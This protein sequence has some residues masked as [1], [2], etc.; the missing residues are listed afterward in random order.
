MDTSGQFEFLLNKRFIKDVHIIL[1]F[2]DPFNKESFE[3]IKSCFEKIKEFNN[4]FLCA[5]ILI[6]NKYDLNETKNKNIMISDEEVLEFADENNLL[7]RNLSNLEKYGPGIE[8]II[9]DCI[10]CYLNKTN[11]N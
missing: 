5:Y 2:Y 10:S 6:K 4:P 1:N 7:F 8:E 11:E 9:E 3:Y